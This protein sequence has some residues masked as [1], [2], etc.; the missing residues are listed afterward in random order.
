MQGCSKTVEI[1]AL[2]LS[3]PAPAP[4]P[5][6]LS[7]DGIIPS[8]CSAKKNSMSAHLLLCPLMRVSDRCQAI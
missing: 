1:L 6:V 3:N 7:P 2:V 8:R 5:D 4:V